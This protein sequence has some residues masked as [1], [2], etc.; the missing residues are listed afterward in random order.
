MKSLI[1]LWKALGYSLQGLRDTIKH[2]ISFR[3]ELVVAII[4]IPIAIFLSTSV[5]SKVFLV[6]S[7]L[8]VLIVEL[9]NSGIESAVNRISKEQH[10]LSKRAKDAGS[11]AVF[12]T[13]LNL[14]IVWCLILFD[15]ISK[16]S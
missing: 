1:H 6:S 16:N 8:L 10:Q 15:L 7:V 5:V 3:M 13:F 2:E 4:L 11:A 12:M 14:I 9:I